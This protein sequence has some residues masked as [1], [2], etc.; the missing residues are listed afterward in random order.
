VLQPKISPVQELQ[1]AS[2]FWTKDR[3]RGDRPLEAKTIA[4]SGSQ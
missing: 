2:M 3:E 4:K 1:D